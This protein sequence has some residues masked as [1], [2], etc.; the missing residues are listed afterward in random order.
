M[1][2]LCIAYSSVKR[3]PLEALKHLAQTYRFSICVANAP[4]TQGQCKNASARSTSFTYLSS[5]A[6]SN[7]HYQTRVKLGLKV[8]RA[9][10]DLII[11]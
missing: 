1:L 6:T 7:E 9:R 2:I 3:N 8:W 5:C 4:G 11:L 10:P